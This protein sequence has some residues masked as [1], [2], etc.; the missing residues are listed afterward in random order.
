MYLTAIYGQIDAAEDVL[1]TGTDVKV[2]N[3]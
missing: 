1:V 3:L 2:S